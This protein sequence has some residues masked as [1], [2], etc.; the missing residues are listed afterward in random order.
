MPITAT[1]PPL[2]TVSMAA[3]GLGVAR[4]LN[5]HVGAV[6]GGA[7]APSTGSSAV[8]SS[9]RGLARRPWPGAGAAAHDDHACGPE[10]ASA[11]G[12]QQPHH[13]GTDHGHGVAGRLAAALDAG[14]SRWG[15]AWP[16]PRRR[17]RPGRRRRSSPS[18]PRS[19][20]TSPGCS[21]R[22]GGADARRRSTEVVAPRHA[23]P[24]A[25]AAR[26]RGARHA[27]ARLPAEVGGTRTGAHHLAH[28]LVTRYEGKLL[29]PETRVVAGDDVRVGAADRHRLHPA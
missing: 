25:T 19:R 21:G 9:V 16:P 14:R 13:P 29:R 5:G 12:H 27:R 15:R 17:A 8:K 22:T 7:R 4:A 23:Q 2:R 11:F 6:A 18:G 26:V 10:G 24:A 20:R 28:P 1:R 3:H